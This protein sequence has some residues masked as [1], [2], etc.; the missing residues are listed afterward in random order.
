MDLT[1]KPSAQAFSRTMIVV[2]ETAT[3]CTLFGRAHF[4]VIATPIAL[5]LTTVAGVA[6]ILGNDSKSLILVSNVFQLNT[7]ELE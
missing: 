3:T 2:K 7:P 1:K 4:I 6:P 5:T